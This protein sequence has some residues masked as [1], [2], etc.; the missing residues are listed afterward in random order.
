MS[1]H[2]KAKKRRICNVEFA[3]LSF[4]YTFVRPI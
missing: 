3:K 2:K 1:Y 4:Y